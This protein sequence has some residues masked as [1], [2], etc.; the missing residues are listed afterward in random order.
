MESISSARL[1]L[2][3]IIGGALIA[4][5]VLGG[6]AV[7]YQGHMFSALHA[8]Q[9][10]RNQLSFA[11]PDKGGYRVQALGLVEQAISATNAGIAAGAQ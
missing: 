8:L 7:A 3:G 6:S 4:G 2:A 1:R 9:V 11:E 10:A 5:G